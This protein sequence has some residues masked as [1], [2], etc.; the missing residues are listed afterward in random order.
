MGYNIISDIN[1]IFNKITNNKYNEKEEFGENSTIPQWL[2]AL[3]II[4]MLLLVYVLVMVQFLRTDV[5]FLRTD[6]NDTSRRLTKLTKAVDLMA[7]VAEGRWTETVEALP[8]L[9]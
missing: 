4:S 7:G 2:Q 3:M 6:G 5:Q 1:G 8:G 9:R